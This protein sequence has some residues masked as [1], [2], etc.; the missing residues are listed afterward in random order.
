MTTL[1]KTLML[2]LSS[3]IKGHADPIPGSVAGLD[4]YVVTATGETR[5]TSQ[6]QTQ[7]QGDV[8]PALV[9]VAVDDPEA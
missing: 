6:E 3:R 9:A 5:E 1:G 2:V 7:S 8:L 4:G